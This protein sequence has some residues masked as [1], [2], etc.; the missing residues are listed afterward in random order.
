MSRK[1]LGNQ[2]EIKLAK[3]VEVQQKGF[4]TYNGKKRKAKESMDIIHIFHGAGS[5]VTRIWRRI[6][7]FNVFFFTSKTDP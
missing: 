2:E 5:L 4:C 7:F 1:Q 3:E 6:I